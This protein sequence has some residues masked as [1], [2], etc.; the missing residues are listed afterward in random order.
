MVVDKSNEIPAARDLSARLDLDNRVVSLDA[1]PPVASPPYH[2]PPSPHENLIPTAWI[3]S[4]PR[5][6]HVTKIERYETQRIR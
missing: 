5:L 2:S 3:P 4:D 6:K 1:T